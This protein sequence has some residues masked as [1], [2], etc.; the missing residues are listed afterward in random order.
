LVEPRASS[1]PGDRIFAEFY[2]G[3]YYGRDPNARDRR[4]DSPH[5]AAA[6]DLAEWDQSS[7]DPDYATLPLESSSRRSGQ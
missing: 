5:F 7:F 6:L 1:R 4:R 3:N 2:Y